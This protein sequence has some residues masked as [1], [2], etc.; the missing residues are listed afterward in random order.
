METIIKINILK[1]KE[2]IKVKSEEQK[3]FKNQRKTVHIIG[4]RKIDASQAR[5]SHN[6]NKDNLR[7]LYAAYGIAKGKTFSQIENHYNEENHPLKQY[8]KNINIVLKNYEEIVEVN[9]MV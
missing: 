3:F 2:N 1:L 9:V 8:Q 6:I 7:I 4:E 5:Y